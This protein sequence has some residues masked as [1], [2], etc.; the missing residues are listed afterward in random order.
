MGAAEEDEDD[1]PYAEQQTKP[2]TMDQ[3]KTMLG[4]DSVFLWKNEEKP[5][6]T[7]VEDLLQERVH[8]LG[9]PRRLHR[10]IGMGNNGFYDE[11]VDEEDELHKVFLTYSFDVQAAIDAGE[12]VVVDDVAGAVSRRM[13]GAEMRCGSSDWRATV[14]WVCEQRE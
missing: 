9:L 6:T 4:F 7:F 14:R 8:D 12:V 5:N 10:Q 11:P 1:M 13:S 3:A 2:I